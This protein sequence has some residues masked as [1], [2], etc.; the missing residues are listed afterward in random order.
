MEKVLNKYLS[1]GWKNKVV[2]DEIAIL[3][4][5][6]QDCSP[7]NYMRKLEMTRQL[8]LFMRNIDSKRR[9]NKTFMRL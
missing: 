7:K 5:G 1:L 2:Q 8:K 4:E 3:N 6:I 9:M